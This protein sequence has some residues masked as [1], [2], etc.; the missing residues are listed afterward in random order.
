MVAINVTRN[1]SQSLAH[2][3]TAMWLFKVIG[4]NHQI[5]SYS[6]SAYVFELSSHT[7]TNINRTPL[8]FHM[9]SPNLRSVNSCLGN[10]GSQQPCMNRSALYYRIKITRNIKGT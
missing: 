9:S 7:K 8:Y 2:N 10:F 6:T 5:A 4:Q 1:K 3:Q